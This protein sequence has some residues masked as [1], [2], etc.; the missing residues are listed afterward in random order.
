MDEVDFTVLAATSVFT[1][2][3]DK[4]PPAEACR[5][6]I[7]RTAKATIRMANSTGGFGQVV[8]P[9]QS[10]SRGSMSEHRDWAQRSDHA[11]SKGGH[12]PSHPPSR[13]SQQFELP[14]ITDAY[15]NVSSGPHLPP[16]QAA[17]P[18]PYR[19]NSVPN[20]KAEP[21]GFSMMRNVPGQP[22]SN[23]SAPE[24]AGSPDTS[25][26]D[27]SLLPSPTAMRTPPGGPTHGMVSSPSTNV[28]GS[29]GGLNRGS[30]AGQL[31]PGSSA[32]QNMA[33]FLA[34]SQA[35]QQGAMS[36]NAFS[37]APVSFSDLQGIDFLQQMGG[38]GGGGG[39]MNGGMNGGMDESGNVD[40]GL[41]LGW[42]G[43]HHDF[44]D[45]QQYDLFDGFFFGG[46]QGGG[47]G[48]GGSNGAL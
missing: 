26:I 28:P 37:P 4:C 12:R 17:P 13:S 32:A 5:D 24:M 42:E 20:L 29:A 2:L 33:A 3:S 15:A 8:K 43:L 10:N 11:S 14:G 38:G 6:A 35:P 23:G 45:G 19:M 27:P 7:D 9:R 44:S 39:G 46:Q 34:H 25:A 31:T 47:G 30:A 1:D 48:M 18:G 21:D 22:R 40:L 41:G 36:A 16:I